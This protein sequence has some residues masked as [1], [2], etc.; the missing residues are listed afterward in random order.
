M[1]DW[2]SNRF[3]KKVTPFEELI[4]ESYQIAKDQGFWDEAQHPTFHVAKLHV[5]V[6]EIMEAFREGNPRSEIF[7]EHTEA[8]IELAD[9][10]IYAMSFAKGFDFDLIGAITVKMEYN[11]T[12]PR[13][14]GKEF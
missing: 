13:M 10:I 2:I 14:N 3:F 11:K 7:P 8:E 6:S 12:R 9:V 1:F 4:D 5:E